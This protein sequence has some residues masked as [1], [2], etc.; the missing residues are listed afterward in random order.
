MF[1]CSEAEFMLIWTGAVLPA[2]GG[3]AGFQADDDEA[4]YHVHIR[5]RST[6][7]EI[8]M[9]DALAVGILLAY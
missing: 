3:V 8:C 1:L 7:F 5:N 6:N 4:G 2:R 9:C